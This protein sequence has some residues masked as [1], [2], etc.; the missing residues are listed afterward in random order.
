MNYSAWYFVLATMTLTGSVACT[1]GG[2]SLGPK[3]RPAVPFTPWSMLKAELPLHR[4]AMMVEFSQDFNCARC[5]QM[6]PTMADIRNAYSEDVVIHRVNY[7]A[8]SGDLPMSIC[9]TYLLVRDGTVVGRLEGNQ[10]YP[11]L[12]AALDRLVDVEPSKTELGPNENESL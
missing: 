3:V 6:A 7:L 9:P 4:G 12:A 2:P 8:A 1:E 11:M 10:P 5:D